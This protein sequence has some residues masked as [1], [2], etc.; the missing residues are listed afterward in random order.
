VM[1]RVATIL[2]YWGPVFVWAGVIFAFSSY[3]TKQASEI[4]WQDF[5]VKKTAHVIEYGVFATLLYRA[6]INSGIEKVRAGYTAIVLAAL[7][8]I[9]DEFHQSFTP[10]REPTLRD[11]IFDTIG[12]I[13]AIYI[14]W[15]YLP[16]APKKLKKWAGVW[17]LL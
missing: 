11:T 7:Y 8:G 12:A 10:G 9:S 4:Y 16:K 13:L 1:K 17:Q 5:I 14:V 3:A 6:F 15:K 2:K